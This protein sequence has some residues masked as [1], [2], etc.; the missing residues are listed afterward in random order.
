[1]F[2]R[3]LIH[4]FP[5]ADLTLVMVI[6]GG[7]LFKYFNSSSPLRS[8]SLLLLSSD[9]LTSGFEAFSSSTF[10]FN[11]AKEVDPA[12]AEDAARLAFNIFCFSRDVVAGRGLL[13][14]LAPDT[15]DDDLGAAAPHSQQASQGGGAELAFGDETARTSSTSSTCVFFFIFIF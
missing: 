7:S 6:S 11:A 2:R 5:S 12:A 4:F 8:S 13:C 1:L 10:F 14:A 9:F 15:P 3:K